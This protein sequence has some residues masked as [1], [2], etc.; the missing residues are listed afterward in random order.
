MQI[1]KSEIPR[2]PAALVGIKTVC[3]VTAASRM[4][5]WRRVRA[6]MVPA[7]RKL[8]NKNYWMAGDVRAWLAQVERGE[9][10][11]PKTPPGPK[12]RARP[13]PPRGKAR[14]KPKRRRS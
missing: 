8:L 9:L 13:A 1:E 5:V 11:E 3:A 14:K 2:D 10:A 6:G 7:P 12:K 4:T